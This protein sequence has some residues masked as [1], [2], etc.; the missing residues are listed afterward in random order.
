MTFDLTSA[1]ATYRDRMERAAAAEA[2]IAKTHDER[3]AAA[4]AAEW[5]DPELSC[6]RLVIEQAARYSTSPAVASAAAKVLARIVLTAMM[7]SRHPDTMS[8]EFG[9]QLRAGLAELDGLLKG[10]AFTAETD[11]LE[12]VRRTLR[13]RQ[14]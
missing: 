12:D 4:C 11:G 3:I 5:V 6:A 1:L 9:S 2:A 10:G 8:A 7:N 14:Q 13:E